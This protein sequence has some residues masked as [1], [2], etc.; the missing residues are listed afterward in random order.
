MI[1]LFN[2]ISLLLLISF[3]TVFAQDFIQITSP[4]QNQVVGAKQEVAITYN[5]IGAQTLQ[6]P[7]ANATYPSGMSLY[8]QWLAKGTTNNPIHLTAI[9]S[10]TTKPFIAGISNKQY[11]TTWKTPGCHFFSRYNPNNYDFSLVFSPTYSG[12]VQPDQQQ[13]NILIP[14]SFQINNSTFPKC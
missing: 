2:K 13:D 1:P 3:I 8:F 7:P 11:S 12:I 9:N 6:P 14:L 10:L 5:V 4:T